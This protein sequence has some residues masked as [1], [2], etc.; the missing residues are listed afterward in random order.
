[1][2]ER[3]GRADC[4]TPAMRALPTGLVSGLAA[5]VPM[6]VAMEVM[7]RELP[8][9]RK[10]PFP[11]RLI[12]RR[13]AR[14]AG[15]ERELDE[16]EHRAVAWVSHFGYGGAMGAVYGLVDERVRARLPRAVR[17]MPPVVLDVAQGVAF[18]LGVWAASY[19]GWLPA[20]GIMKPATRQGPAT[21]AVIVASHV[22]YGAA[23]GW[24][25][26]AMRR[27]GR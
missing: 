20:A 6:S 18:G 5:T 2:G 24:I 1:M 14:R 22:V 19:L 23:L 25:A 4:S 8:V 11:P 27:R 9:R 13:M 26:G 10:E 16:G 21:N 12:T 3:G 17:G 15:V 7:N